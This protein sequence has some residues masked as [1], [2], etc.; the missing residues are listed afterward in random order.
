[1]KNVLKEYFRTKTNDCTK[2]TNTSKWVFALVISSKILVYSKKKL[3]C[4]NI[5]LAFKSDHI[6]RT[7]FVR[8]LQKLTTKSLKLCRNDLWLSNWIGKLFSAIGWRNRCKIA[9]LWDKTASICDDWKK[10]EF[11]HLKQISKQLAK[12]FQ[13]LR[14]V[15]TD[16]LNVLTITII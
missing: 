16:A 10:E 5:F 4:R 3:N 1:M 9:S 7:Q 8:I 6:K 11:F 12:T 15:N 13:I 14:K 2:I